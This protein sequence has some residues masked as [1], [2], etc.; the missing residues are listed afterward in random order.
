MDELNIKKQLKIEMNAAYKAFTKNPS[1]INYV[2]L[3]RAMLKY[4][5][6]VRQKPGTLRS[7]RIATSHQT[8]NTASTQ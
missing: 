7:R 1:A 6:N 5:I 2:K 4:Q 8:A 3:E